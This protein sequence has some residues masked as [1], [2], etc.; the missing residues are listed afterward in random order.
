MFLPDAPQRNSQVFEFGNR[1]DSKPLGSSKLWTDGLC[2]PPKSLGLLGLLGAM[3][4]KIDT[5]A[6]ISNK[7]ISYHFYLPPVYESLGRRSDRIRLVAAF[8]F[9]LK[10]KCC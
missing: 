6:A 10:P 7:N 5:P 3:E 1:L 9:T 2:W 4:V 8:H